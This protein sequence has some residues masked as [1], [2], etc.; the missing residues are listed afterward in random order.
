MGSRTR[1]HSLA[2]SCSP[3]RPTDGTAQRGPFLHGFFPSSSLSSPPSPTA[4][5]GVIAAP[6]TQRIHC[7]DWRW[8]L[9]PPGQRRQRRGRG[10]TI[11]VAPQTKS[12]TPLSTPPA[13]RRQPTCA[14]GTN[15]QRLEPLHTRCGTAPQCRDG[16]ELETCRG[17]KRWN[18]VPVSGVWTTH[19]SLRVCVWLEVGYSDE[20]FHGP[21][22]VPPH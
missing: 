16:L 11:R 10:P 13:R 18:P 21:R 22:T 9:A 12:P 7:P 6:H 5:N 8:C 20:P 3:R 4:G 19:R 14:T 1:A 17:S 2:R 15:T